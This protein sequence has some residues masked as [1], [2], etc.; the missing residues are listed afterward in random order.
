MG[1]E[2]N[3]NGDCHSEVAFHQFD[4]KIEVFV[5]PY[6]AKISIFNVLSYHMKVD[7]LN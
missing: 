3:S 2:V 5:L 6:I 1:K 4:S 7:S